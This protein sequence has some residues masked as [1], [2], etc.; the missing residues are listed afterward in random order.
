[1]FMKNVKTSVDLAAEQAAQTAATRKAE[2]LSR[3]TSIDSESIRSL[4]AIANGTQVAYD[5]GK[6]EALEVERVNLSDELA[7]LS[8]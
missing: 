5:I 3:L 6:I 4:R 1:M 2:I 8:V 7:A